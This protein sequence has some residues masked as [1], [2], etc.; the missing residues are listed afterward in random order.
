MAGERASK[1]N[2]FRIR[3]SRFL[4]DAPRRAPQPRRREARGAASSPRRTTGEHLR[5]AW[6][7]GAREP[8]EPA[9]LAF[10]AQQAL[11]KHS[12]LVCKGWA[13]A[14]R[15]CRGRR[16]APPRRR[17]EGGGG[18]RSSSSRGTRGPR[19]QRGAR[20]AS[21]DRHRLVDLA[22][23]VDARKLAQ[24]AVHL[25]HRELAVAIPV[26]RH[27][28]RTRPPLVQGAGCIGLANTR[29]LHGGLALER[30]VVGAAHGRSPE[31]LSCPRSSD[32]EQQRGEEREDARPEGGCA[33][34]VRRR[35][36]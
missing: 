9:E 34:V 32:R 33:L 6:E 17:A 22:R 29:A 26:H 11:R 4:A 35:S 30:R 21:V 1:S 16:P 27:K 20:R 23:R 15:G 2:F 24:G 18:T 25:A 5:R 36:A 19:W 14:A 13:S 12:M 28:V 31:Q 7:R 8:A 3:T 10:L